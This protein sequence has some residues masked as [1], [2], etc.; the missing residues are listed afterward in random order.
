[1][2][3]DVNTYFLDTFDNYRPATKLGQG[4]V[5]TGV[6]DSVIRGVSVAG[7]SPRRQTPP[8]ADPP[9]TRHSP[10][11]PDP[12]GPDT[13]PWRQSPPGPDTLPRRQTPSPGSRLQHTVNERPVRILLK[14]ILVNLIYLD[15]FNVRK[16]LMDS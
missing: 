8:E 3:H 6:C 11:G 10:L 14:C 5:F 7:R 2:N 15:N 4:N 13:P 12:P 1:M 9:R 16:H